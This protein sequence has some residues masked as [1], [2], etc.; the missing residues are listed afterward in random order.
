MSESFEKFE[1]L[2]DRITLRD[3]FA[4]QALHGVMLRYRVS[5]ASDL[6]AVADEAYRIADYML[7]AREA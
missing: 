2:P 3:Y 7:H 4:A 1:Q 5:R 6:D